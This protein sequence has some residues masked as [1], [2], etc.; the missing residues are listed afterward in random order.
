VSSHQALNSGT[1]RLIPMSS[2]IKFYTS[3]HTLLKEKAYTWS[4]TL[5]SKLL[6]ILALEKG[7]IFNL[8]CSTP[9][10]LLQNLSPVA[11]SIAVNGQNFAP[12][13]PYNQHILLLQ[14]ISAST[15]SRSKHYMEAEHYSE[16]SGI[17]RNFVQGGVQ[18]I[19]LRTE[20]T[21]IWGR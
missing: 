9:I 15:W 1:K 20:R 5:F 3:H 18:Q 19:Q 11:P 10:G 16:T 12:T 6:L 8:Q 13:F 14:I 21:G 4:A 2:C 7:H 17:P